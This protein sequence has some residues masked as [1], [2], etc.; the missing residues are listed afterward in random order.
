M[1]MLRYADIEQIPKRFWIDS[2]TVL[3]WIKTPPKNF[4]PFV[5][6]RVAEIQETCHPENFH[7]MCSCDN[8]EDA[9]TRGINPENHQQWLWGPSFL[10]LPEAEWPNWEEK[11]ELKPTRQPPKKQNRARV[12]AYISTTTADPIVNHQQATETER[13]VNTILAQLMSRCSSFSKARRNL[14]YVCQPFCPKC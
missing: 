3:S 10:K 14:A 4:R 13:A 2:M 12:P 8:S 9:L 5:S 1:E 11:N 7:Y 6:A